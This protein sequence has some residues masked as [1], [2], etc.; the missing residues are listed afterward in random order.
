MLKGV[1]IPLILTFLSLYGISINVSAQPWYVATIGSDAATGT[2]QYPF[3][4]I[5][6]AVSMVQAGETIF[7]RGGTYNLTSTIILTKSGIEKSILSMLAFPGEKPVLDFSGQTLSGSNFGIKVTGNYWRIKGI[8]ISGAGDNGMKIEGG[9]HNIIENCAFYRNRDSGLQL[10]NGAS[11]N[12]IL[13]CDSYYN[14]DP[15]DYGDADGFSPKL[16]AGSGN[17]FYGCRAWKNCDDGFDGYLRGADDIS[18]IL[19]NCWAFENGYLEDGTDPG[20]NANGNGFKMG[21]SD[22]KTLRHN[23]TLK[24]CLAFKN[25][26]KGFD[27]NNN[28]GSMILYNCTGHNN[29]VAD[30]RVTQVLS[31]GKVLVLKN[32]VDLGKIAEIGSFAQQEKNSW[33]GPFVTTTDDFLTIN[34]SLAYASRKSDG[35]LPDMNYLHL[36]PGSDLIDA[37]VDVGLPFAGGGPDLGCFETG[38]TNVQDISLSKLVQCYPNPVSGRGV[39]QFT[40]MGKGRCEIRLYD[41]KGRYIKTLADQFA[42]ASKQYFNFD[43]WDIREGLYI[44]LVMLNNEIIIAG[45]L[46]K[47]VS[48][49]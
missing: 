28:M 14:A 3:R 13:N 47:I 32:C 35:A 16:T 41:I 27:Q 22:D 23:F 42:L 31:A 4:S 39:I 19:E 5:E 34:E 44:Y 7:I 45:K 38:L 37:G 21:G 9:S 48:G 20:P 29:L 49:N 10:D 26:G 11:D 43:V 40:L 8:Y 15:P 18:T 12:S 2:E 46:V 1:I 25:K 17:Y 33:M 30:Y 36:A 6:K 24:K